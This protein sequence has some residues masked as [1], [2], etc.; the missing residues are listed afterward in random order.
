MA[1]GAVGGGALGG[2]TGAAVTYDDKE[3]FGI[4]EDFVA[5]VSATIRRGQSALFVLAAAA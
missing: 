2:L 1:A 3:T 5:D 4:S